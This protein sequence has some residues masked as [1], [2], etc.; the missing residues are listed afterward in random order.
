MRLR[1]MSWRRSNWTRSSTS[2]RRWCWLGLR[3][4]L[5]GKMQ[6]QLLAGRFRSL[7]NAESLSAEQVENHDDHRN[8]PDDDVRRNLPR[9]IGIEIAREN[10]VLDRV[11]TG[12]DVLLTL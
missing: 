3:I 5:R 4:R 9:R 6:R 2:W 10:R 11:A 7:A 8:R 12:A 1:L